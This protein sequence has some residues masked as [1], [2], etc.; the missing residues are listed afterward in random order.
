SVAA[1]E[2]ANMDGIADAHVAESAAPVEPESESGNSTDSPDE[3]ST[4]LTAEQIAI[5][6]RARER[7]AREQRFNEYFQLLTTVK[8]KNETVDVTVRERIKGGL[9]VYYRD[10]PVFLPTSHFSLKRNPSEQSLMEAINKQFP[11]HIHELQQ[12]ETGRKTVVVSRKQILEDDFWNKLTVGDIIEGPVTSIA[13]FGVFIDVSGVEG[14][15]H[16]SRVS[17][18]RVEDLK[19]LFKKGQMVKVVIVEVD[20]ERKRIALSTK[21]LEV[22]PWK[23]LE[24]QLPTGTIIKGVL[25]QITDFG[26]YFEIKPGFD[27]LV[28]NSEISWTLRHKHPSDVLSVGQE[29]ELY[30]LNVNVDKKLVNLSIKKA[31]PNP[32]HDIAEKYPVKTVLNC[33]IKQ[34]TP[35]GA[36]ISIDETL[37]AFLPL[38]RIRFLPKGKGN[39]GDEVEL[40]VDSIDASKESMILIPHTPDKPQFVPKEKPKYEHSSRKPNEE[41]TTSHDSTPSSSAF[42]LQDLISESTKKNLL[43]R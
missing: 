35:Q 36:I 18:T 37:D 29:S 11:V 22:S 23:I 9:R 5:Q 43:K 4:E 7:Q 28:R 17:N 12:D 27:G 33:T 2:P 21:E 19:Q 3:V 31:Q 24:E 41:H 10:M 40:I 42:T 13:A 26:A 32:W 34:L 30:V 25:K 16:I 20:K 6:K 14:L 15:L 38:S 1:E 8:E 39:V